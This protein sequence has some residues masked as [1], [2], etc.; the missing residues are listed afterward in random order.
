LFTNDGGRTWSP[1]RSVPAQFYAWG[2]S[3]VDSEHCTV[4]GASATGATAP[5]VMATTDGGDK[6]HSLSPPPGTVRLDRVACGAPTSCIV[7]GA[8]ATG[9]T[10]KV[11]G[12]R[13]AVDATVAFVTSDAGRTWA[14]VRLPAGSSVTLLACAGATCTLTNGMGPGGNSGPSS[15]VSVNSGRTWSPSTLDQEPAWRLFGL[16]CDQAGLCVAVGWANDGTGLLLYSHDGGLTWSV[17]KQA[18][19]TGG[20]Q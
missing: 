15:F 20:G 4:V 5:V 18:V 8:V 17:G 13:Q 7:V 2:I 12:V 6:W 10:T 3:C 1:L 16:T 14:P 9:R 19:T 11:F